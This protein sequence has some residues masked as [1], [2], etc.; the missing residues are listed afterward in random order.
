[1]NDH[2]SWCQ[3]RFIAE[4]TK[5]RQLLEHDQASF[6]D[7]S[8]AKQNIQ[9][10]AKEAVSMED[11]HMTELVDAMATGKK[12]GG[13]RGRHQKEDNVTDNPLRSVIPKRLIGAGATRFI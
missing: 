11:K 9:S 5:Y 3:I 10:E 8:N 2:K 7:F 4:G 13:E 1:V 12:A 6:L